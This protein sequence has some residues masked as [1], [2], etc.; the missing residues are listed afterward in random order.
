MPHH[1]D[2]VPYRLLVLLRA[3]WTKIILHIPLQLI[4]SK[5]ITV[6]QLVQYFLCVLTCAEIHNDKVQI[7]RHADLFDIDSSPSKIIII[8]RFP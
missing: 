2:V 4:F 1:P 3:D 7:L 8:G 5:G 6:V